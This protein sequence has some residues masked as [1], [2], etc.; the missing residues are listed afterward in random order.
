M[1]TASREIIASVYVS[2][3]SGDKRRELTGG[4][5]A[6]LA[7]SGLRIAAGIYRVTI[8]RVVPTPAQLSG[9]QAVRHGRR[10][11]SDVVDWLDNAGLIEP[12]PVVTGGELGW[13]V[14]REG[15]IVLG[16]GQ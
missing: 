3:G 11:D 12:T 1:A 10:P 2:R 13:S 8:R 15:L 7:A 4:V 16:E 5:G 14:T 9:L 6:A